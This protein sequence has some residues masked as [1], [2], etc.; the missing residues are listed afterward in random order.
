MPYALQ[1]ILVLAFPALAI[2]AALR[3]CTTFTIPNWISLA[4]MGLFPVA[5]LGVGLPLSGIGVALLL[6]V[7][8]LVAGMAMFA[9]GWIGGGDA[10][11]FAA[12]MPWL[13][14]AGAGPYLMLTAVAGGV[15][16]GGLL[17]MR[18]ATLSP[19]LSHGPPWLARLATRGENVPYGVAIAVGALAAF[20]SSDIAQRLLAGF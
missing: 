1:L 2:I 4:M 7:G 20:P 3:D 9:I 5:A 14:L 19:I 11:M 15:L 6:G 8:G 12:A 10:K 16:A 13:G 18:S 17:M